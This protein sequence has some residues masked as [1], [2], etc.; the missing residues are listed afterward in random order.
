MGAGPVLGGAVST[1]I[2][3]IES[4]TLAPI[5]LGESLASTTLVAA[6]SSISVVQAVFPGSDEAS[7]SLASFATLVRREWNED[8][9][10]EASPRN[11]FGVTEVMKALVAWA[12]LQGMTSEWQEKRWFKCL[13][14][15]RV[16]D[17]PGAQRELSLDAGQKRDSTVHVTRDATY[18]R[19][20]INADIGEASSASSGI[21]KIRIPPITGF[22][23]PHAELKATLRR[24]S[25]LV[26]AG[27]G[28]ASL[29]F[30]GVPPVPISIPVTG[31]NDDEETKLAMAIG[32][33]E[34]EAAGSSTKATAAQARDWDS[35]PGAPSYSWW[36]VLRG[37]H[38]E[39]ILLRYAASHPHSNPETPTGS[40]SEVVDLSLMHV[41]Y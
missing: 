24:F 30:F 9:Q 12:T 4:L 1:A 26:L 37:K 7:F 6:Q 8:L 39:D 40:G 2:S 35:K 32:S 3:A 38:D 27:Y 17:T 29:L 16:N 20:I 18:P 15:L 31:N 11:R 13:T 21:P 34:V 19:Q 5:L 10:D 33:S 36:D 25:K 22:Q 28:G 41:L 23:D 14:E